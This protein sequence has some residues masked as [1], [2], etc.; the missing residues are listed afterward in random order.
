VRQVDKGELIKP[1]RQRQIVRALTA[2]F[3]AFA[4]LAGCHPSGSPAG[5][6]HE[7]QSPIRLV[8]IAQS[9]GAVYRWPEE[10]RP[11]GIKEAFGLGCAFIDYDNDG[12]PDIF[13]VARPHPIL[14]HNLGNGKFEDVTDR[15]GLSKL[16]GFWTGCAVGDYDGDGYLDLAVSG[17]GAFALL[18]NAGGETFTDSTIA[19]GFDPKN[20]GLWGSGMGFMDLAGNGHLDLVVLNYVILKSPADDYCHYGVDQVTGCPPSHYQAQYPELWRNVGKGRFEDATASSGI[21][22]SAGKGLVL[23]FADLFNDGKM[24]FVIGNDGMTNNFMKNLGGMRFKEVGP[25]IGLSTTADGGGIATM[26]ADWGDYDRDGQPDLFETNFS[27]APF[28]LYHNLGIGLF[29]HV[30]TQMGVAVP[31]YL[32]LGF[33]AKWADV[34]NDGWPD[35]LA[36]CGHVY[37][38]PK[39]ID[40]ISEFR[41]P[42][43]LLHNDG[44]T[45]FTNLTPDLGGDLTRPI[46]GRGI[47]AGDFDNDGRIDFVVVDLEGAMMLLHNETPPGNHWITLDLHSPGSNRFAYGAE[48]TAHAGKEQWTGLVSPAS[49]Y[50]SS[51]D[52]RIHF[53]LGSTTSLDSVEIRWPDGKKQPIANLAADHIWRIDEGKPP[54]IAPNR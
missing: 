52:P 8:D 13:L 33:G 15:M 4:L 40:G 7:P 26:S 23:A 36:L 51:S 20:H 18:K 54:A 19:A 49:G 43:M 34:D 22:A 30:E 44:G 12:W 35:I 53:G 9:S 17:Y 21:R 5:K 2:T 32:P 24:G 39:K 45:K 25:Q 42:A 1:G 11:F 16:N 38:D 41:Q 46:L 3:A 37:T 10:P 47:A 28:Q 27:Q 6:I 50:M 14:F 48:I 31:P 29:E